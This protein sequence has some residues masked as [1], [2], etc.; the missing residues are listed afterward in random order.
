MGDV[1][2]FAHTVFDYQQSFD[3]MKI[4]TYSS[5]LNV[6]KVHSDPLNTRSAKNYKPAVDNRG[7]RVILNPKTTLLLHTDICLQVIV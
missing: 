6:P 4:S 7:D 2:S 1:I 3:P 5:F